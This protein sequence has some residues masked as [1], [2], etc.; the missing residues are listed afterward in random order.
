M[1]DAVAK[2]VSKF[3]AYLNHGANNFPLHTGQEVA[4]YSYVDHDAVEVGS[5][6]L[7]SYY[8]KSRTIIHT[9]NRFSP[10]YRVHR[11]RMH[12]IST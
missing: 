12:S 5:H 11:I 9:R 6:H 4:T 1:K 3:A 7:N 8:W 10:L 2:L